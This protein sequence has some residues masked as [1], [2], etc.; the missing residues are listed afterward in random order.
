MQTKTS[1]FKQVVRF[2]VAGAAGLVAY[3]TALYALTEY[4]GVWYVI[5]A[6]LG[7]V[8]NTGL[9]FTF[10]K[11]WTFQNKETYHLVGRQLVLYVA[12]AASFLAGNSVFLYLMVELLHMWYITAQ[13][14]LTMVISVLSFIISSKIFESQKKDR[15]RELLEL[16]YVPDAIY[17]QEATAYSA[18]QKTVTG[19]FVVPRSHSYTRQPIEYVTAEQYVRC[20]SQLSYVLVGFLIQDK[21]NDFDLTNDLAFKR[22]MVDCKMWFRRSDLRYRKNILKGTDFE[23]SLTLKEVRTLRVFSVCVLEIGG[24]IR[25]ELE[26]VAPINT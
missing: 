4:F 1:R 13:V 12:M 16:L 25:G 18:E 24:V 11:F 17:L 22:L 7:F 3:Y 26:F 6:T 19:R 15:A 8:L 23:L 9:N 5:S 10:Q 20:L 14:I 2:C 21:V